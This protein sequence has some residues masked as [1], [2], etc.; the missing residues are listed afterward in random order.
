MVLIVCQTSI[1][2]HN[3]RACKPASAAVVSPHQ[4]H[5]FAAGDH[6]VS[7]MLLTWTKASLPMPSACPSVCA[8][9][10]YVPSV[11]VLLSTAIIVAVRQWPALAFLYLGTYS[12]W[13]Y[14]RFFQQQPESTVCGDPSEDFKFSSFFPDFLAPPLDAVGSVVVRVLR[15]QAGASAE[16][17]PLLPVAQTALGSNSADA[18]R[19]RCVS[20][21]GHHVGSGPG[22]SNR[23]DAHGGG[24]GSSGCRLR[25]CC[26]DAQ[27]HSLRG[28]SRRYRWVI[29]QQVL[30][31]LTVA[32]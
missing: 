12:S 32:P 14:L 4:Q 27:Q 6:N 25:L 3:H 1:Q 30:V 22:S 8:P 16:A 24:A 26:P 21:W 17:K 7:C 31:A 23:Q 13:V 19:R 18:N 2:Q 29:S 9:L 5:C 28:S 10:Q 15:L 11:Y 20:V